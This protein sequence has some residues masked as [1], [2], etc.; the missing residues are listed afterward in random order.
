VLSL[1][2]FPASVATTNGVAVLNR[3]TH[4]S[5]RSRIPARCF[6]Y[7]SALLMCV[8]SAVRLGLP[9][10]ELE[11]GDMDPMVDPGIHG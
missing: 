11:Y 6:G 8:D 4:N 3:V 2:G 1:Q 9:K 5:N 7:V 10:D